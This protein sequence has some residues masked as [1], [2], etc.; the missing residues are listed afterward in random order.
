[1]KGTK[2]IM[3]HN[4]IQLNNFYG[5]KGGTLECILA[6]SPLDWEQPD[7]K[8][9]AVIVVPGGGYEGCSKRE[10]QPIASF[11]LSKGFQT[12][13]LTYLCAFD[14]V[15]YPEQL[16]ELAAAVDYVKT[17]AEKM[18]INP[19]E[20]FVVGFSAGGHL[21]GD[22]AVE[23][24]FIEERIGAK[25]NCKPT[26]IGLGYPVISYKCGHRASHE[27]LV[28]GYTE[29]VKEKLLQRLNL[30][31][32]V[33]DKTPPAFLWTTAEDD[34]VPN[35]NTL[36]YASALSRQGIPYELHVYPQGRHGLSSCDLEI[37]SE[38]PCL[39]KNSAWLENCAN[40]FRLFTKEKF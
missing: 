10:G 29:E 19:E 39:K 22:L 9:P 28:H 34:C 8:R 35:I 16:F 33:T 37:N 12:F 25:L 32:L 31:E 30:D 27:S 21:A 17:Y 24:P 15:R 40:F 26:A 1:M 3:K 11:F 18:F 7:W 38:A 6:E 5:V 20:I 13:I 4:K 36:V 23:Y 14:D 2:K